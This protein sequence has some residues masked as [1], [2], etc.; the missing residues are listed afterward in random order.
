MNDYSKQNIVANKNLEKMLKKPRKVN[1][2]CP[3]ID[4]SYFEYLKNCFTELFSRD[5]LTT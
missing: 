1:E 3:W 2:S 4:S 5:Q